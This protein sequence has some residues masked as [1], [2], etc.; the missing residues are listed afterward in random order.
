MPEEVAESNDFFR[1]WIEKVV[2]SPRD[3]VGGRAKDG[4]SDVPDR[5][6]IVWQ[7]R[8]PPESTLIR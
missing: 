8:F 7:W 5:V 6:R 2:V 3:G 1:A 4:P